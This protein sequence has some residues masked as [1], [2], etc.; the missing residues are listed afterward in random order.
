MAFHISAKISQTS[1]NHLQRCLKQQWQIVVKNY[2]ILAPVVHCKCTKTH[3][4]VV[5]FH[6]K[7]H[8]S[9]H[10]RHVY[11]TMTWDCGH[12]DCICPIEH[13]PGTKLWCQPIGEKAA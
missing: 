8:T 6:K 9:S 4:T 10:K 1:S 2:Q 13:M 11:P 5:C 3:A 12:G 7:T